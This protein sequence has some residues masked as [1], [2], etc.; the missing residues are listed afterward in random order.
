MEEK[1][2]KTYEDLKDQKSFTEDES[3]II[4]KK[5]REELSSAKK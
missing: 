4:A 5:A 3:D 2:E 1:K